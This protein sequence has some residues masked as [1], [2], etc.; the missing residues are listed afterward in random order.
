[1]FAVS[2][3]EIRAIHEAFDHGGELAAVVELRRLF[4]GIQDNTEA[5]RVVRT[6]LTWR[7]PAPPSDAA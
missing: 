7:R 4:R 1:M 3:T 6:I 2:D 5:Q